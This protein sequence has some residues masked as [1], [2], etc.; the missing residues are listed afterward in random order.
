[1]KVSLFFRQIGSLLYILSSLAYSSLQP[2]P[3][4]F[5]PSLA[6]SCTCTVL[7][8]LCSFPFTRTVRC[9]CCE[10]LTYLTIDWNLS[11]LRS[12]SPSSSLHPHTRSHSLLHL[13][14]TTHSLTIPS[15][16]FSLIHLFPF[17]FSFRERVDCVFLFFFS[18]VN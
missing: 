15:L 17:L 12:H 9:C 16:A 11:L 2:C 6:R 13:S 7:S 14:T 3:Y 4:P 10:E 5:G 8:L 18:S 1:M